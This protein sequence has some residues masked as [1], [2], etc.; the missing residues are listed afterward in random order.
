MG[1]STSWLFCKLLFNSTVEHTRH[2]RVSP[3]ADT[4][5]AL[6][7]AHADRHRAHRAQAT[8]TSTLGPPDATRAVGKGATYTD[9]QLGDTGQAGKGVCRNKLDPQG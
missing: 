8:A 1:S 2:V 6:P 5:H 7:R 3:P 9:A 4:A